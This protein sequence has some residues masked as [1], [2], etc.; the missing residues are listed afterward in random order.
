ML[1][2]IKQLR[3]KDWILVFV[4]LIF[5]ILQVW[6]EL[7]MPDYMSQITTLVQTEGSAMSDIL[8]NGGF[9]LL[10]ALGSLIAA[11]ITGYFVAKIAANFS[12]NLRKKIFDQVES[13]SLQEVK[14]FSTSSLITR[15]TNDVTQIEMLVAMGTQLLLKAPITAGQKVGEATYSL[16]GKLLTTVNLVAKES[17]EKINLFTMTKEIVYKWIDLLRT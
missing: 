6:L 12:L 14:K 16:D 5:V 17:V 3:K 10:C 7:K 15:T 1:K 11:I 4:C 13:F 2:L 9:M 8:Y